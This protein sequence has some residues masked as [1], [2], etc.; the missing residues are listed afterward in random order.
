MDRR[1]WMAWICIQRRDT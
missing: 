1:K